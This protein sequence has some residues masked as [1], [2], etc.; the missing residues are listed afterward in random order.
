VDSKDYVENFE[1][2]LRANHDAAAMQALAPSIARFEAII[3]ALE[4]IPTGKRIWLDL[5]PGGATVVSIDGAP[6]GEPIADPAF[7][8]A[9]LQNWLGQNPVQESLK[10]ELLG[11]E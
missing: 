6:R 1:K 11:A 3:S 4:V 9:V 5:V 7:Y 10:Q 8:P 2:A